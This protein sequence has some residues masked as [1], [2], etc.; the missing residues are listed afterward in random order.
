ML[1]PIVQELFLQSRQLRNGDRLATRLMAGQSQLIFVLP[2][3]RSVVLRGLPPCLLGICWQ[4][5]VS[6]VADAYGPVLVPGRFQPEVSAMTVARVRVD[7]PSP[8]S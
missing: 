5:V 3:W 4:R 2:T 6:R 1:G 8:W 7:G